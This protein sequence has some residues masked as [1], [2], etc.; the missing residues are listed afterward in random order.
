MKTI[1][2]ILQERNPT[3][4]TFSID[5]SLFHPISNVT[6]EKIYSGNVGKDPSYSYAILK[7]TW[8][9][10]RE[11]SP[12]YITSAIRHSHWNLK[13]HMTIHTGVNHT[14]VNM[15]RCP[16]FVQFIWRRKNE[17][18]F[19]KE[20]NPTAATS[21]KGPSHSHTIVKGICEPTQERNHT[22]TDVLFRAYDLNVHSKVH[23]GEK[24]YSC[25]VRKMSFT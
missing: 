3:S 12:S 19:I 22:L 4:V 11:I 9:L 24:P 18:E 6:C 16:L 7:I 13:Q 20:R 8:K 17:R 2:D 15:A 25:N 10:T 1:L 23:I 5:H 14:V 21:V